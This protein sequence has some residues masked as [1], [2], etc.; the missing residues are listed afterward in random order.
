M[1]WHFSRALVE[2]SSAA[3]CSG[4]PIALHRERPGPPMR[5]AGLGDL[6]RTDRQPEGMT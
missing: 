3:S 6:D 2:A 5:R 4:G 1:S